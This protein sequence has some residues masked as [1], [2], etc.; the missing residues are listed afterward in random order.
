MFKKYNEK[1]VVKKFVNFTKT[2]SRK[3]LRESSVQPGSRQD[4]ISKSFFHR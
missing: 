4:T 2:K 3:N 1:K